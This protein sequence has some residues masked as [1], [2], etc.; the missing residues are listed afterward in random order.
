MI[1]LFKK[2]DRFP[3]ENPLKTDF[4]S[5]L[6]P[7]IDDGSKSWEDSLEI[8][9]HFEKLGYKKV[10]TTPHINMDFY[11][12]EEANILDL[13]KTLREKADRE[14]INLTIEV[15]AEYYLDENLNSKIENNQS[16]LLLISNK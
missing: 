16:E 4:H 3:I 13:G 9:K 5:H 8:L 2:T 15:A 1:R 11:P 14:G 7:G 12:N 10:I 6:I